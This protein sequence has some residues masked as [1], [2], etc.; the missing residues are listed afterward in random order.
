LNADRAPQLKASVRRL[1]SS[2][3]GDKSMT[4]ENKQNLQYFAAPS[5]RE[6]Y[7][8][9]QAW[10]RTNE[11]RLLSASIHKDRGEFCCI[12]LTNPTEVILANVDA[13]GG[14]LKVSVDN[15]FDFDFSG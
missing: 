7:D 5:M 9:M 10:Q 14:A 2:N 12:A 15:Y 4:D 13:H 6:L 1:L 11:K 3:Y 8:H